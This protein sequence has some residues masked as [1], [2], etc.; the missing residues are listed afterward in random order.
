VVEHR[1]DA[2]GEQHR[3][4][5]RRDAESGGDLHGVGERHQAR[6]A[7][8]GIA[9]AAACAERGGDRP[10]G[11][12]ERRQGGGDRRGGGLLAL[13]EPREHDGRRLAV[14]ALGVPVLGLGTA[15]GHGDSPYCAMMPKQYQ[16]STGNCPC[17]RV[18]PACGVGLCFWYYFGIEWRRGENRR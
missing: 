12:G 6:A 14:D 2:A 8:A 15:D 10:G 18:G 4:L 3:G 1:G 17:P 9:D 5:G 16:L 7:G 11:G 13:E